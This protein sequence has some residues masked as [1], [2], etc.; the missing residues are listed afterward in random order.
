ML[1][2]SPLKKS[3]PEIMSIEGVTKGIT[4]TLLRR[5][6]IWIIETE[7]ILSLP[8]GFFFRMTTPFNLVEANHPS[9]HD[10]ILLT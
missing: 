6:K 7:E 9:P 3:C 2:P 10:L 1:Q 5:E 8:C 4:S